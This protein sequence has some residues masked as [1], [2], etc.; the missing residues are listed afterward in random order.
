MLYEPTLSYFAIWTP[1]VGPNYL[2]HVLFLR[3]A[4]ERTFGVQVYAISSS[5][6]VR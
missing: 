4:K 6:E 3:R 1:K 2:Q 5:G